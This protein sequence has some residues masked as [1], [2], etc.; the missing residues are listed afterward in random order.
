MTSFRTRS[1]ETPLML[2]GSALRR[3]RQRRRRI[4]RRGAITA[5]LVTALLGTAIAPVQP[6]LIW[7]ASASV[8]V[9]LYR[10]RQVEQLKV[11]E[12]V[13]VRLPFS[14]RRLAAER[15][16]LPSW[17]PLLKPVAAVAGD[18][19]CAIAVTIFVNGKAIAERMNVDRR[20]RS[21]PSWKG[22]IRLR[23]GEV[24]VLGTARPDSFDGR[25]FGP[26]Q[27]RDVIGTARLLWRA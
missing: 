7:N 6:R 11:G 13:A 16:Y 23:A 24:F 5:F 4:Q 10:V 25:Y 27:V 26:T 2:I 1:G 19:V 12:I 14:T 8:P 22:C 17:T 21:L 3:E 15:A 9:G 20:G 18:Q